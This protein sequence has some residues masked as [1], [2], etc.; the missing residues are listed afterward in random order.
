MLGL[1]LQ[2]WVKHDWANLHEHWHSLILLLM[3][4]DGD[5]VD[6]NLLS[7]V[8]DARLVAGTAHFRDLNKP[9]TI[10]FV[11]RNVV[12]GAE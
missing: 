7:Y 9:A 1:C 3:T 12:P 10:A 4:A 11:E 8:I 5:G 6:Q 2:L